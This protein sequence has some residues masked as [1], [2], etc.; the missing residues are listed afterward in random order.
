MDS[1]LTRWYHCVTRCV[2]RS[3]LLGE[4]D[5]NRNEWL[6]NRL[7]ELAEVSTLVDYTGRLCRQGKGSISAELA[8]IFDRLGTTG[9][10]W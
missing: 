2:R 5:H 7:E 10:S 8:G 3:S 9:E 6:E 4:E 1:S